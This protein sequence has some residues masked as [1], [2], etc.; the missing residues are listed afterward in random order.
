MRTA[1]NAF[2]NVSPIDVQI[3]APAI[4]LSQMDVNERVRPIALQAHR[5][6]VSIQP[7]SNDKGSFCR[8]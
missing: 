5:R 2:T 3:A 1:V 4:E 6:S 8:R 7:D